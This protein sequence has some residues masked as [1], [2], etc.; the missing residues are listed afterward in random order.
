MLCTPGGIPST[1]SWGLG[2]DLVSK[3][4]PVFVLEVSILHA[5]LLTETLL[6]R[7][8]DPP[9]SVAISV[10]TKRTCMLL[11]NWQR[12]G[13]WML[14]SSA[15]D[16]IVKV[17][18]RLNKTLPCSVQ[19]QAL[20]WNFFDKTHP[21][22]TS[23]GGLLKTAAARFFQFGIPQAKAKWGEEIAR[24]PWTTKELK[25]HLKRRY[26]EDERVALELLAMEGSVAGANYCQMGLNRAVLKETLRR[27]HHNRRHQVVL[28]NIICATRFKFFDETGSLLR[29]QC[30]NGCGGVDSLDHLLECHR[31]GLISPEST[32]DDK[33]SFLSTMAVKTARNCPVLP[34]PIPMSSPLLDPSAETDELS[35]NDLGSGNEMPVLPEEELEAD[36]TL[37]FDTA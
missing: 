31:L 35:L 25:R 28:A 24:I 2:F 8:S 6:N 26:R 10:G 20:P 11:H 5:L 3:E 36:W 19:L 18:H 37:E 29:V 23:F 16:E 7:A 1:Q 34:V 22:D 9:C 17:W 4:P 30:P 12:Y 13:K 14:E 32:F 27:L 21:W 33:V 15:S